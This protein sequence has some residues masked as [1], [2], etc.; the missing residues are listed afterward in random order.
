MSSVRF[1]FFFHKIH[2]IEGLF[3]LGAFSLDL[4]AIEGRVGGDRLSE[5]KAFNLGENLIFLSQV[6]PQ[7]VEHDLQDIIDSDPVTLPLT[8]TG[9]ARFEQYSST[10]NNHET[11]SK[12]CTFCIRL[13]EM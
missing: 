9:L 13:V 8:R 7:L 12:K 5:V 3:V 1:C 2:L 11:E 4:A 6:G 10:I